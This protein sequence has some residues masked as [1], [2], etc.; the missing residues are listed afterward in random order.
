MTEPVGEIDDRQLELLRSGLRLM[1][2]RALGD[3]EAAEEAVQETLARAFDVLRGGRRLDP[4]ELGAFVGGIARHVIVDAHRARQRA[5]SLESLPDPPAATATDDPLAALVSADERARLRAAL[6]RL[7]T[8]DYELLRL[9]FFEA[10]TPG[11]LATRLR[12]P[13]E[14]IRKRKSRALDRLRRAFFGEGG[15]HAD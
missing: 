10:L 2:L 9:S 1:A 8:G 13:A 11:Q 7:S 6:G 4:R 3:L 12:Q 14:R 5:V 15:G